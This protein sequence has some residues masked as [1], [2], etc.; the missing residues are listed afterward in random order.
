MIATEGAWVNDFG[1]WLVNLGYMS[2]IQ[3]VLHY[4]IY[5]ATQLSYHLF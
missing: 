2:G 1:N 5:L 4:H 3:H